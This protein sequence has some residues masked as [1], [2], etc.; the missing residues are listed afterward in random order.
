MVTKK[1]GEFLLLCARN[2]IMRYPARFSL[3]SK[4][5][6]PA[7]KEKK[8][9]FVSIRLNDELRGCIGILLPVKPLCDA[10]IESAANAAYGD[11][12]F[13]EVAKEELGEISIEI[14]VLTD[15]VM[16]GYFN[17]AHL[18]KKLDFEEGVIVK[19]GFSMATFLPQ[20]WEQIPDK[21]EF[22]KSLCLKA[23]LE[24]DAWRESSSE[25]YAYRVE[26]FSG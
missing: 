22:L 4:S 11:A 19:K 18:L 3:D 23:G 24:E 15:P 14:S 8:G 21:E 20:V 13:P 9:V 7:L 6:S 10:V 12:R 26:K 2:S 17:E 5:V 16:L 1:E 25:V